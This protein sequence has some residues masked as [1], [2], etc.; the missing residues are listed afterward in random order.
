MRRGARRRFI[1]HAPEQGRNQAR[2]SSGVRRLSKTVLSAKH[3]RR[4]KYV[5]LPDVDYYY[6]DV[7]THER[8]FGWRGERDHFARTA[9][10]NLFNGRTCFVFGLDVDGSCRVASWGVIDQVKDLLGTRGGFLH[11]IFKYVDYDNVARRT[12]HVMFLIICH[13]TSA[14]LEH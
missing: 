4:F 1:P 9:R 11:D 13:G 14:A 3:L 7:Y 5:G 12:S 8:P 10:R 6:F 2:V